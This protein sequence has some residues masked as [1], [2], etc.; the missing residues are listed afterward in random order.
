M[1]NR[2]FAGERVIMLYNTKKFRVFVSFCLVLCG[3]ALSTDAFAATKVPDF[4]FPSVSD[5]AKVDIRDFRGKVVLINFWATW[6]GP[7]VQEIPSLASLQDVYGEQGFS[8]LGISVDQGGSGVVAK[9]MKKTGVNYPVVVGNSKVSRDFG[10]VYG[11][12]TSFLVDRSGNV[13][14][15]YTGFV[16]HKVFEEDIK[17]ALQ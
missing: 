2:K 5:S 4:S 1:K 3:L 15:R 16:G 6:C 13:L 7:C 14:K 12:P 8:V 10:G 9:M 11:V 17:A